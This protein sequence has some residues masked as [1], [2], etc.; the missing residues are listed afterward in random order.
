MTLCARR[1]LVAVLTLLW[2]VLGLLGA[3]P[4]AAH[5]EL[6]SS[7]PAN[8]AELRSAP[9]EVR[10]AFS[11]AVRPV[12]KTFT[13][14]DDAGDA[15]AI[16]EPSGTSRTVVT[17]LPPNLGAGFYVL[18][19]RVISVDN[20]PIKG[21][22]AFNVTGPAER[23]GV[24]AVPALESTHDESTA[25]AALAGVNRWISHLGVILLLGVAAFVRLC[26]PA[27]TRDRRVRTGVAIG[28]GLVLLAAAFALPL[29]AAQAAG[30]GL[31]GAFADGRLGE[32]VDARYGE[33]CCCG[34]RSPGC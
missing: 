20:H 16:V 29:Q 24:G 13:L 31:G 23:S 33:P 1:A 5:A 3:G 19:F 22:V 12:R 15:V 34:L 9:A 14:T 17:S 30:T 6:V 27:G 21:S 28:A 11:E 2:T 25:V 10:L 18:N 7:T 32:V 4:A 8:G 26:W